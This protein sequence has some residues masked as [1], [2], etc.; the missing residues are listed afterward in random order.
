MPTFQIQPAD[1]A[2][3]ADITAT[4]PAAVLGLVEGLDCKNA[5]VL[6]D[7]VYTFSV[8]LDSHGHWCVYQRD[9]E[10]PKVTDLAL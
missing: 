2:F 7:G 9:N 6:R 1:G 8:R 3:L 10:E 4:S 5:D